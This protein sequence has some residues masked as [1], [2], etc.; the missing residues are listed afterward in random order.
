MNLLRREAK[1]IVQDWCKYMNTSIPRGLDKEM[2][3]DLRYTSQDM[4]REFTDKHNVDIRLLESLAV[5]EFMKSNTEKDIIRK[6]G[7]FKERS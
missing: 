2:F 7:I 5:Y 4:A 3:I 6:V 1:Q